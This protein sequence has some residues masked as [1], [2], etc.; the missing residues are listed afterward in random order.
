M[1]PDLVPGLGISDHHLVYFATRLKTC[2]SP[3]QAC[4]ARTESIERGPIELLYMQLY[5]PTTHDFWLL[6]YTSVT[7]DGSLVACER[8]LRNTQNGPRI[9]S[10]PEGVWSQIL[11][12][13]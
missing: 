6:R 3:A 11:R 9:P 5:A 4:R 1:V 10:V 2:L 8:S 7:E 13:A 12:Q